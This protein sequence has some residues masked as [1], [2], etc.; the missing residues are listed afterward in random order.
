MSAPE[1]AV[2]A[3]S[4]LSAE[5]GAP[6]MPSLSDHPT[7]P[8]SGA[9]PLARHASVTGAVRAL[10]RAGSQAWRLY[11]LYRARGP[12]TDHQASRA[13]DLPLASICA[14]RSWLVAQHLVVAHDLVVGPFGAK[15]T[16]WTLTR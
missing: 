11:L 7:L 5:T 12:Q 15:N 13:L 10:P 16:R 4:A 1:W 14:R 8:F 6:I 9:G 2:S 3:V